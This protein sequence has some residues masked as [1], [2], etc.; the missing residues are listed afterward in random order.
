[1]W[2]NSD[3]LPDGRY[4]QP[5]TYGQIVNLMNARVRMLNAMLEDPNTTQTHDMINARKRELSFWLGIFTAHK[6]GIQN[7]QTELDSMNP[8]M[9]FEPPF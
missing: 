7:F 8:F 6:M 9:D 1:M 5:P 3:N 2:R 4:N